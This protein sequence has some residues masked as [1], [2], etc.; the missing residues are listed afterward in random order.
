MKE[1]PGSSEM[2]VLTRA[3]RRNNPEDTIL[4]MEHTLWAVRTSQE[5]HHV[6]T[7]E[8]SQ[9][10]LC[11]GTVAV[12]CGNRTEHTDTCGQYLKNNWS[13]YIY[14]RRGAGEK[15]SKYLEVSS[16]G[17]IRYHTSPEWI[18]KAPTLWVNLLDRMVP[19]TSTPKSSSVTICTICC[20]ISK[21]CIFPNSHH[22]CL[23]IS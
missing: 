1:A 23:Y 6:S 8:P 12:Y 4:R 20:N 13:S 2:S 19:N 5:T 9:L 14:F 10:M 15:L 16:F 21:L 3:T 7:T 17:I 18:S 11:G 22:P